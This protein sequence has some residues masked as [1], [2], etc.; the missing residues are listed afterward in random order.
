MFV[1]KRRIVDQEIL[2]HYRNRPCDIC[3]KRAPSDPSHIKTVRTGGDDAHWNLTSMCR[4]CHTTWH[5]IGISS[6]FL[7]HPHFEILLKQK[8]WSWD[9]KSLIYSKVV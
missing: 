9:G 1:K 4:E 8:G 6:F 2:E 7:R 3:C 5:Q